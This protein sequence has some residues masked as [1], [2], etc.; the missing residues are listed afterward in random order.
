M[1]FQQMAALATFG[2]MIS[3]Y[4]A[5]YISQDMKRGIQIVGFGNL[6]MVSAGIIYVT[7]N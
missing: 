2:L 5:L 7:F 3:A 4:G 6:I 1:W